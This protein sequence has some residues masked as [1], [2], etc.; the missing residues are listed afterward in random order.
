[1]PMSCIH[2]TAIVDPS[3]EIHQDAEIGP[4]VIIKGHVVIGAGT[5]VDSHSVIHG[6]TVIGSACRIGPSAFVG[7]SPQ[8]RSNTGVGT[9]C[10]IGDGTV[11]RETAQVHRATKPGEEYATRIG[12]R[13]FMMAG[14]HVGHDCRVGDD[15][16]FAN[17]VL[18]GGHVVV[19]NNVF[20]GGGA[21]IHQFCRVGRLAVIGGVEQVTHDIPPF[22][23]VRYGGLKAYNAIGCKRYGFDAE[24]IRAIRDAY[25]CLHSHR[26]LPDA[27]AAM[28]ETVAALPVRDEIIAFATAKGRGLPPSVH[29]TRASAALSD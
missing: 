2:P 7:L 16:T 6:H 13:C 5:V 15:V 27:I 9:C 17:A 26:T 3:A 25:R 18:L 19:G 8:H 21:G 12:T 4:Y 24:S 29:F 1:M 20:F 23:A 28:R 10:Y 14:S 22:A 11:I